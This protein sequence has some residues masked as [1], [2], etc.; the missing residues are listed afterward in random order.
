MRNAI[1]CHLI[2][3]FILKILLWLIMYS[4]LSELTARDNVAICLVKILCSPKLRDPPTVGHIKRY[5]PSVCL[6]VCLSICSVPVPFNERADTS[7]CRCAV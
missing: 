1:H 2:V 7:L 6:S 5:T 4:S 3:A